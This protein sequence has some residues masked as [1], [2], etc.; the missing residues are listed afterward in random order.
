MLA[1]A[2]CSVFVACSS[3]GRDA[4]DPDA[5]SDDASSLVVPV[6]VTLVQ[7]NTMRRLVSAS[8]TLRSRL[9]IPVLSESAGT[10]V[11]LEVER[12]DRVVAGQVIARID[13]DDA[14][15]ALDEARML[16]ERYERELEAIRPLFEQGY[17]A[18]QQWDEVI[19]QRDQ[20]RAQVARARRARSAQT[21]RA[22]RSGVVIDRQVERGALV[23]PNQILV[24]LA[25][26]DDL[27]AVIAVPEREL[28][29]LRE[30]QPADLHIEA[31]GG[32]P[33]RGVVDRIEPVIDPRTGTVDVRVR[34]ADPVRDDDQVRVRPGMFV[35][36]RVTTD[37]RDG[38]P[39]LLKRA[40]VHEGDQPYAWV[41]TP[42]DLPVESGPMA[43]STETTPRG[44]RRVAL[45]LGYEE[46]SIVEI[47]DGLAPGDQ[48]VVAGQS[49]LGE[50]SLVVVVPPRTAR[51]TA[52]SAADALRNASTPSPED[53]P[54]ADDEAL[55]SGDTP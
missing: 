16:V 54:G 39:T 13:N 49:A 19:F 29:H 44:V 41:V 46:S 5:S 6:E 35:Q 42:L 34:L 15:L 37:V 24:V 7:R 32:E 31:L 51:P 4:T 11:G 52:A 50:D 55:G 26:V 2:L 28:A 8:T 18:R 48:V 21:V 33:L 45:R 1:L 17:L 3:R 43:P 25:D 27:E 14:A 22:P 47:L 38:V 20:A 40:L 10:L 23:L 36:V 9:E 12:G 53:E 30:G